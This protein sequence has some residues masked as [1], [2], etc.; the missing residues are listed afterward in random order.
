MNSTYAPAG[1]VYRHIASCIAAS[2]VLRTVSSYLLVIVLIGVLGCLGFQHLSIFLFYYFIYFFVIRSLNLSSHK[3]SNLPISLPNQHNYITLNLGYRYI[4]YAPSWLPAFIYAPWKCLAFYLFCFVLAMVSSLELLLDS[5]ATGTATNA[6]FFT[7]PPPPPP[8]EQIT[9]EDSTSPSAR[10]LSEG[11]FS[12]ISRFQL[13]VTR[14]LSMAWMDFNFCME[15]R[16]NPGQTTY[17]F[18]LKIKIATTIENM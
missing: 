2:N 9:L 3:F 7:P 6:V 4:M 16:R 1:N 15:I 10:I 14:L 8:H 18:V 13:Q 5:L 12:R 17:F 11:R